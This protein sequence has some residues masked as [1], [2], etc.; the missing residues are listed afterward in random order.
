MAEM[1]QRVNSFDFTH[2]DFSYKFLQT[3]TYQ[4]VCKGA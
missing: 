1:T 4:N 2:C 3:K